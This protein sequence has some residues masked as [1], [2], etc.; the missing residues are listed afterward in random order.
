MMSKGKQAVCDGSGL[1]ATLE[2]IFKKTIEQPWTIEY[3]TDL[4]DRPDG[5]KLKHLKDVIKSVREAT[6]ELSE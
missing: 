5:E 3:T 1:E 6:G 2:Q 4:E